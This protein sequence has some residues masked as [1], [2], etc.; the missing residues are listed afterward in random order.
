MSILY[1]QKLR[2]FRQ[3]PT[4][5]QKLEIKEAFELF[6]TDKDSALDYHELKVAMRALGFEV[7][8]S[9]V[10]KILREHDKNG[11]GLIEYDDFY[12]IMVERILERDPM[13]E[14]K[15]AFKLFDEDNTGKISLKNLKKVAKEIG[16]NLD[17]EEL[18]GMIDEFDL[19]QDGEI[20]EQEFFSIMTEHEY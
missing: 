13:E 1:K 15:K 4:E 3:E 18:Q 10:L 8:K 16:E 11:K 5:E 17:D 9:E 19:D 7:K 14:M 6:D 2:N 20:N 12:K